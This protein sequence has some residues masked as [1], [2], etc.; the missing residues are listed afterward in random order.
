MESLVKM[1][2]HR[3][4]CIVA[5]ETTCKKEKKVPVE[6]VRVALAPPPYLK[7]LRAKVVC[8]SNTI[9]CPDEGHVKVPNQKL[10]YS[11]IQAKVNTRRKT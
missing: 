7:A 1:G 8:R 5:A 6:K 11:K 3:R 2:R 9:H 4:N 10:D